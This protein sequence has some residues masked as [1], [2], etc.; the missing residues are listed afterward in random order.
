MLVLK[1][2]SDARAHNDRIYAIISGSA[3][4]QD[5]KYNVT[6]CVVTPLLTR[7]L[8][9]GRTK[10]PMTSPSISKQ[11]DLLI[12]AYS[13]SIQITDV[14]YVEAHGTGTAIGMTS[15]YVGYVAKVNMA[16]F[17]CY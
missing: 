5:G 6:F 7:V 2:L 14:D 13:K 16:V 8:K 3:V 15:S 11:K 4:N 17:T 10:T 1:R 12:R 9:K